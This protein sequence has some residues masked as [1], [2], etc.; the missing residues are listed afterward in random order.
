MV[1]LYIFSNYGEKKG[2]DISQ[3]LT[4]NTRNS[5]SVK[6]ELKPLTK[7]NPERESLNYIDDDDL[8]SVD[9]DAMP[10]SLDLDISNDELLL[11]A[12]IFTNFLKDDIAELFETEQPNF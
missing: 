10:I 4:V 11:R 8:A 2:L 1:Y 12:E 6:V 9:G 3:R 7:F 5:A